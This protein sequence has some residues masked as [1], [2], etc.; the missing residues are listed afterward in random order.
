MSPEQSR[1]QFDS[2]PYTAVDSKSLLGPN[3]LESSPESKEKTDVPF[4]E[5][6]TMLSPRPRDKLSPVQ[7]RAESSPVLKDTPRPLSR[8]RSA[9]SPPD[10][11][12]QNSTLP[13][14]SQDEE[15]MEVVEKS[16]QTSNQVLPSMSPEVR[17][18][19]GGNF[20]S[21]PEVE[22]KPAV[23]LALDQS[24]SQASLE[25]VEVPA[26]TS[27]WSG[28]H[29]SP[30]HKELSHSPLRENSFES[31]LGFRNSGPVTEMNTEFSP[32][33][34]EDLNG[35]F[36]NQLDTDPSL[37]IK[38]QSTRSSRRSSS[39]SSPDAVEKAGMSSNQSVSSPVLDAVPRTPSRERSS[40]VSSP[41][42][43]DGL[44]RTPSRRSRSGSSPGL[45]DGS[46]TPSR[47]SLSGSSPGM[48]DIPRTPSRGQSE[49]DSSPEPKALPQTPRPRSH[50]P[51]SPELNNKGLTPQR[52]RSGSESSVE[53]KTVS[54][55]PLGQRS[56]SGE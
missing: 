28:P 40:S 52:E 44:P 11:K 50:S 20:E 25:A 31:T 10:T 48:K 39:E 17:E 35:P 53:Q 47:H 19:A 38:E 22:E 4:Q 16:E 45:R 37:D 13:N 1:S 29:I 6:V 32:E 33:V 43:K 46:G 34:K 23:S 3:R 21:S 51:S 54:R 55:T 15:L 49:C 56:R 18:M 24:Q 26:V 36:L 41:E 30:E 7:D 42:L 27:C 5:N 9:G 2:S 12:N 14:S 8:E